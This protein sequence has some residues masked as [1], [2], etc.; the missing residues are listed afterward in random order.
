[1]SF[2]GHAGF[3]ES[4]F[5]TN[6]MGVYFNRLPLAAAFQLGS[7]V[8]LNASVL[9]CI[10]PAGAKRHTAPL[11]RAVRSF[12]TRLDLGGPSRESTLQRHFSRVDRHPRFGQT[13]RHGSHEKQYR[14]HDSHQATGEARRD[15]ECSAFP[16]E[17]GFE[18]RRGNRNVRGWRRW[19]DLILRRPFRTVIRKIEQ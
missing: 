9:S 18:L 15:R 11:K 6:V 19:P 14:D 2:G 5:R 1:M 12:A 10:G 8:V 16:G 13:W 7:A 3:F 17:R 4:L